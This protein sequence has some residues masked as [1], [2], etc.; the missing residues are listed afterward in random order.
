MGS[1]YGTVGF[2]MRQITNLIYRY[3]GSLGPSSAS[4]TVSIDGSTPQL[5][6]GKLANGQMDQQ[7]IWSTTGLGRGRHNL[8]LTHEDARD[9]T[10]YLDFFRSVIDQ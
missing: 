3:Y 4:F 5:A 6:N 7:L 10:L 2:L 8:T 1:Q 9:T